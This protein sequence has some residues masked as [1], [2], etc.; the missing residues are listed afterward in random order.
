MIIVP[1]LLT[2][3]DEDDLALYLDNDDFGAQE[4][5][6]GRHITLQIK[7]NKFF[8]RNKKGVASNFAPEFEQSLRQLG[9][10]ILLDGEHI[11]NKFHV[12][13]ILEYNNKNLRTL[14]YSKRYSILSQI[15][16]R[17]GP[18]APPIELVKIAIGKAAKVALYNSLK[19]DGKEGIVFKKL[20]ALFTPGKGDDQFKFKFYAEA[21][22][23]VVAGRPGKNSIGMELYGPNGREFVGFCT[24]TLHP[25]PT[26]NSVAEIKYLYAHKGG[27]LTQ[28]SF[29][30]LRDDVAL[31]ECTLSQLKYKY[32]EE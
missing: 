21:S 32:E 29:K 24:C 9:C 7:N 2:P 22:V 31:E 18:F 20:A 30:E 10:D 11:G 4:K 25:L 17:T 15:N 14:P 3:I 23:I 12:W 5:K 19:A 28:P 16:F 8:I 26:I 1:Q 13:D 27:C 6:N